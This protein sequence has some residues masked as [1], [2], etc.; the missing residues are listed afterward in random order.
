M[1]QPLLDIRNNLSHEHTI[2]IFGLAPPSTASP[3]IYHLTDKYITSGCRGP[4]IGA[5]ATIHVC[6]MSSFEPI[7]TTVPSFTSSRSY[8]FSPA[9]NRIILH[10]FRQC[11]C[12]FRHHYASSRDAHHQFTVF[13][14]TACRGYQRRI[15]QLCKFWGSVLV[16]RRGVVLRRRSTVGSQGRG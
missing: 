5:G 12:L 9:V 7:S 15:P 4:L 3:A 11:Q 16:V 6:L 8:A 13:F 14:T 1:T 10:I 2:R